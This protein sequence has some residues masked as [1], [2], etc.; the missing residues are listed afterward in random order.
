MKIVDA[1][2]HW[3]SREFFEALC[4]RPGYPRTERD[5]KGGYWYWRKPGVSTNHPWAEWYDLDDQFAYMDRL[6]RG[7]IDVIS[8]MGPFAVHFSE[9]PVDEG[10]EAALD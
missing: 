3:L 5:G 8:T 6:G 7:R 2:F 1:H 9:L 4:D 10:R